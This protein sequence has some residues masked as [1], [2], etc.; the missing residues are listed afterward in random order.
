MRALLHAEWTKFRTVRGWVIGMAAVVLMTVL[1][2][3]AGRSECSYP[4]PDHSERACTLPVGP[5]G[6]AVTDAFYFVHQPLT[7]DGV[8]TAR[9]GTL[10]AVVDSHG[11]RAPV[12]VPWSKAGIMVKESTKQGSSYAA[13]M[14]T[15]GHGVRMQDDFTGDTAGSASNRWLRLERKGDALTGYE[16]SDGASWKAV[17]TAT[18]SGLP[19]TVQI[20]LFAASPPYT[21]VKETSLGGSKET[22][23]PTL[24]TATFDHVSLTGPWTGDAVATDADGIL[25][26]ALGFQQNGDTLTVTGS[27]DIA[28]AVPGG[29]GVGTTIA[30]TLTGTFAGLIVVIVIA[31]MFITAEYRRGLIR[32][33]LAASPHRGRVLVAKAIVIGAVTFVAGLVAVGIAV[34]LGEKILRANGNFIYPLPLLTEVRVMAGTA[35]LLA[36]AAVLA[37]GIAAIFRRSAGAVTAVIVAI[38]L[39]YLLALAP[40]LPFGVAQWLLRLTPAAA[41]SIQQSLPEYPQVANSYTPSN[42]F[43]PLPPWGGFAVLCGYAAIALGVAIVLLRRRDA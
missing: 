12:T 15:G 27:G 5:D 29:P 16:S 32:L 3:L 22:G 43:F 2:G 31:T 13:M 25:V 23:G 10:T 35:G 20:G 24:A 36:V 14:V 19:S 6:T 11:T 21:E 26:S 33:T 34:P 28:P 40:V 9:V 17:G 41:F 7:G 1:V 39:P 18:L 37:L 30:Q 8:I 38:V 4:G 42:G